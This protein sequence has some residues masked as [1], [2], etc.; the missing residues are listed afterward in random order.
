MIRLFALVATALLLLGPTAF[1]ENRL[2]FVVGIDAYPGLAAEVQ[3]RR[4]V[5]DAESVGDA[6]AALGFKVTRVTKDATLDTILG[7][8]EQFTRTIEP[9]DTVVFFY[10]GHG[11]SLDDG[12]YLVPADVPALGPNDERLAKRHAIPERDI[13]QGLRAAGARVSVVVLDA[14][15][16]NPFPR[17]GTRAIGTGTRGLARIETAEGVYSLYSA[18]EGQTALDRLSGNDPDPNSVFTRVFL[19]ELRTPGSSLG[20]GR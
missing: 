20:F 1:A 14:C 18:R 3:L 9:G 6:L 7:G 12:N 13:K 4:A 17:R 5:T 2:A 10:A 19:R 15:R 8:F 16:D 11:I